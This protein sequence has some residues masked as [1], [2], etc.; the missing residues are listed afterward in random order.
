MGPNDQG[1]FL[2]T[3][4]DRWVPGSGDHSLD[5]PL[6]SKQKGIEIPHPKSYHRQIDPKTSLYLCN[7]SPLAL[8]VRL[9][10]LA[11]MIN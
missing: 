6:L 9:H 4:T 5:N 11:S 7:T 8:S 3:L 2:S 1:Y 10:T